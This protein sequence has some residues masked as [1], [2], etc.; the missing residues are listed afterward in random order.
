MFPAGQ[1]QGTAECAPWLQGLGWPQG[2][3]PIVG[4]TRC[5]PRLAE[6]R[7][8]LWWTLADT[9]GVGWLGEGSLVG[10]GVRAAG[11][12]GA[13]QST[14]A[15]TTPSGNFFHCLE[16]PWDFIFRFLAF[17]RSETAA[18]GGAQ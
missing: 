14:E 7:S 2:P 10:E 16:Q 13:R 11:P 15:G 18:L 17:S 1:P 12:V 4:G 9:A 5:W 6:G 3:R 8:W